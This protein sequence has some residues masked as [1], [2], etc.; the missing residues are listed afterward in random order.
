VR[1]KVKKKVKVVKKKAEKERRKAKKV[2]VTK[3]VMARM[4]T[5]MRTK[6]EMGTI[7]KVMMKKSVP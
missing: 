6:R 4:K 5:A 1:A 3:I 2:R 7:A